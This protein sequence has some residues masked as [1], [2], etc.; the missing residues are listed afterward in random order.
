MMKFEAAEPMRSVKLR[1]ALSIIGIEERDLI[2][3]EQTHG[4]LQ[5]L[6]EKQKAFI[7]KQIKDFLAAYGRRGRN[8][9]DCPMRTEYILSRLSDRPN[10][11]LWR[12]GNVKLKI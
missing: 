1:Q 2:D 9:P 11:Y 10:Y 8:L 6:G 7:E 3:I 12:N 4:K 5:S